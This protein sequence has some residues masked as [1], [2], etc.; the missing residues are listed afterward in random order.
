MIE[1]NLLKQLKE[2]GLNPKMWALKKLNGS[3]YIYSK[4][5]SG[6]IL[7]GVTKRKNKNEYW[8]SISFI[9]I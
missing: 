3:Y 7:R 1:M 9:S 8:H 5:D 6:I 2:F 4:E